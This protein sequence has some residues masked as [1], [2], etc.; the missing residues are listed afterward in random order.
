MLGL[1]P[2]TDVVAVRLLADNG[3][4][5]VLGA[6]GLSERL[7]HRP[8]KLSG[9]EQQRVA[10]ARALAN[11]PALVL[12]DEPTGNLDEGTADI[13]FA[14]FLRLVREEGLFCGGS[15]GSNVH[16][17]VQIAK[18]IGPGKT[19]VTVLPAP[20]G[21]KAVRNPANPNDFVISWNPITDPALHHYNVSVFQ[22]NSDNVTVVPAGTNSLAVTGINLSTT[23]RLTVSSR[24]ANGE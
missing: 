11:K 12:A 23:Y 2:V 3:A 10:V 16:I 7:T 14:E 1:G 15:S 5:S 4:Q 18:E 9:G 21:L 17:A 24:D 6:L 8:S 20:T 13:V 19:V 22:N